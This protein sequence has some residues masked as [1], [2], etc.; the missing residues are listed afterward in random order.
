MF[1]NTRNKTKRLKHAF[2]AQ[3]IA[4]ALACSTSVLAAPQSIDIKGQSLAEA[5]KILGQ[6]TGLQIIYNADL[7]TGKYSPA[8]QGSYESTEVLQQL[9]NG[10]NVTFNLSE[11]TVTLISINDISSKNMGTLALT[12]IENPNEGYAA[13]RSSTGS[14]TDTAIIDIPR[15]ISVV[16]RKQL[17]DQ[18]VTNIS[19]ALRYTPGV[20]SEVNGVNSREAHIS[21]RGFTGVATYVDG[22]NFDSDNFPLQD[23]YGLERVE[24][25]RGPASTLYGSGS[26]AGVVNVTTKRPTAEPIKEVEILGGSYEHKEARFDFSGSI[27][28]NEQLLYRLTGLWRDSGSQIDKVDDDKQYFAPTIS[29]KPNDKLDLTLLGFYQKDSGGNL[30]LTLPLTGSLLPNPNGTISNNAFFGEPDTDH[31]EKKTTSGGWDIKYRF[32]DQWQLKHQARHTESDDF[33]S[34]Y[35]SNGLLSDFITANP[36]P[37]AILFPNALTAPNQPLPELINAPSIGPFP[38]V[39]NGINPLAGLIPL[40]TILRAPYMYRNY[41]DDFTTDTHILGKMITG[42]FEHNLLMGLDYSKKDFNDNSYSQASGGFPSGLLDAISGYSTLDVFNPVYGAPVQLFDNLTREQHSTI[43]QLGFYLQDQISL[44]DK[45][46]LTLGVRHD[47]YDKKQKL[48]VYDAVTEDYHLKDKA[49]T[50]QGGINYKF[51]SGLSPYASYAES[52]NPQSG[53]DYLFR[54]FDPITGTQYEFGL[55]YEMP[56]GNL[57]ATFA[58][59]DLTRQNVVTTDELHVGCGGTAFGVCETTLGEVASKGVEFEVKATPLPELNIIASFS[60]NDVHTT[61]ADVQ[62]KIGKSPIQQPEKL[63][64]LWAKYTFQSGMLEG[65]GVLGGVR[66]VGST[67]ADASNT[68]VVPSHSVFDLGLHYN[69]RYGF[70][71]ALNASNVTDK[72][73]LASCTTR[74]CSQGL[75]RKVTVSVKYRW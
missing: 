34:F 24:V 71:F 55:K 33:T 3:S 35:Y 49:T 18:N 14:K 30:N 75:A 72:Y 39:V 62:D 22:M 26:L 2:I 28:D 43:K 41:R 68:L 38:A 32:N 21:S 15:S 63:A 5:L 23:M 20:F 4:L 19:E 74:V 46:I 29:W 50:Y 36:F 53:E 57:M 40:N 48:L 60:T 42:S 31:Y 25:L 69:T 7:I 37:F 11:N 8:V 66:Y 67:Y 56:S 58:W 12:T 61:K 52:F 1:I 27:T 51:D 44:D 9:L 65:F 59:F 64:S 6:Q 45:L 10:S 54:P 17:N 73:Y 16:T 13:T 70:D 47:D